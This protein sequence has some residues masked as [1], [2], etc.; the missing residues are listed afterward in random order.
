MRNIL[1]ASIVLLAAATIPGCH[2]EVPV[3]H[4]FEISPDARA[5]AV[6]QADSDLLRASLSSISAWHAQADTGIR[7]NPPLPQPDYRA[8]AAGFPCPLP[9]ELETLW[10]WRNGE[11][12]DYFGWYHGF[13]SVQESLEQYRQLRAEPLFG[14]HENWIPVFQFEDE[15]YVVECAAPAVAGAPVIHFFTES[16]PSYAYTN[17]TRYVQTQAIAMERGVLTWEDSWWSDRDDIG[18]FAGI[19]RELNTLAVFPYA[20]EGPR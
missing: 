5:L 7:L 10:Q 12:T 14:W 2:A 1:Y 4:P 9:G 16:G 11:S 8:L 15:W 19:H 6:E 17:L 13:L 18:G 20:L 3:A